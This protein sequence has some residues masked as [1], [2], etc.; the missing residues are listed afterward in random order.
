[1]LARRKSRKLLLA[2][3]EAPKADA[4]KKDAPKADSVAP[5]LAA[6]WQ[7]PRTILPADAKKEEP[8]DAPLKPMSKEEKAAAGQEERRGQEPPSG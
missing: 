7:L 1:M 4:G 3:R 5:P 6:A 2:P 8:K